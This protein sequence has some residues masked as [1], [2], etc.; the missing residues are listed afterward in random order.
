M[1]LLSDIKNVFSLQRKLFVTRFSSAGDFRAGLKYVFSLL[2]T[3]YFLYVNSENLALHRDNIPQL[4]VFF[5]LMTRL[6]NRAL[7]FKKELSFDHSW[8][9]IKGYGT[10]F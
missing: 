9:L 7:I 10:Y 8:K 3:I 4:M 5:I 1:L 6:L 2:T